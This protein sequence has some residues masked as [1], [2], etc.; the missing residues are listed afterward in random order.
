MIAMLLVAGYAT[1]LYP[2]TRDV[3]KALLPI[4]GRPM[5]DLIA[6][7]I[8]TLPVIRR[9]I[10]VSNSKYAAAFR[11]WAAGRAGGAPITV[12]DDGTTENGE[13]LGAVGDM[14]FGIE[15]AGIDDD[16][17]VI[18][19][20]NLFDF[21]LADAVDF[22]YTHQEDTILVGRLPPGED[23]R[24]FAVV[25]LNENGRVTDLVEKP[26]TPRGDHIAYAVYLYRRETLPLIRAYLDEGHSPDAPGHFPEWLFR[27]RPIRAYLFQG[28]CIDIGTPE[29]YER[30]KH[31]LGDVHV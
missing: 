22:F 2:L 1:R 31:G 7:Q 15:Q 8:D 21:Q 19:G 9:T 10:V 6:D 3:P 23:A 5:L 25:Q 17:L 29:M 24:R 18:A 27:Q 4:G 13:R 20:D 14:A 11:A 12:L 28:T 30:Y 16:L 26:Q